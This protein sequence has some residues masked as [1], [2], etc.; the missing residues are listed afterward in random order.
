MSFFNKKSNEGGNFTQQPCGNSCETLGA[1]I[2][3]AR[4]RI[5]Y[6]QE[7]FSQLVGVTP[8]AVSK[9]ENDLSCPDIMLLP[10]ISQ[11]LG[12]S[13][14]ELL[15]N[16]AEPQENPA[17]APTDTSNLSLRIHISG[18]NR[19]PVDVAV[20]MSMVKK[21]TK[22]GTG[23]AGIVNIGSPSVDGKQIDGVFNLINEGVTGQLL[24]VVDET[25]Q[26]ITIE[27]S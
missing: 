15:G 14:D 17:P 18:E 9:W 21:F 13:I 25:G 1:K 16:A 5:G 12:I 24:D 27:I 7:E 8:Q 3:S 10:K 23:I 2:S 4:K 11:I 19:K 26:H 6:T 20:P 22:L